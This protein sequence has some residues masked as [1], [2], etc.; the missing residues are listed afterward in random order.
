KRRQPEEARQGMRKSKGGGEKHPAK[1]KSGGRQQRKKGGQPPQH[2]E[3]KPGREYEMR[4][5]PEFEHEHRG[6]GKLDGKVALIT[7]GDSGIGRAVALAFAKEGADV[8]IAYLEEDRD[9]EETRSLVEEEG[10]RCLPIAGDIREEEFC[11]EL[12]RRTVEEFG[13]LD[14]LVNNAA[15]QTPQERLEDISAEQLESTFR[16]NIFSMFY[17]TRAAL[18]HLSEGSAIVNSTSVTAYR[19]SPHLLDYSSTKGAIVSFTRS[20]ALNLAER[21][22]R[23]NAVAPGPIWTPLIPSTFPEEHVESFGENVPLK[24]AGQ[25]GE[26]AMCYVFLAS[27]DSSYM[28]GQV[29]HPNGGEIING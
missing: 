29:L 3:R 24:R 2:Q 1:A 10:R 4:P 22:I 13:R 23:V 5:K 27:Q 17:L 15:D 11:N 8:V 26:V 7:G 19:G 6:S 9:A 12:I 28:T 18:P 20:L 25:P 14:V 16:T 21:G